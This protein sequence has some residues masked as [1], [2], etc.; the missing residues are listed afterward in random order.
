MR[1]N[2]VLLVVILYLLL[3]LYAIRITMDFTTLDFRNVQT[4]RKL[5]ELIIVSFCHMDLMGAP[6]YTKLIVLY[7]FVPRLKMHLRHLQGVL[8]W[9]Q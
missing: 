6:R 5:K 1:F 4:Y 2:I 3:N 7:D 8:H 9:K